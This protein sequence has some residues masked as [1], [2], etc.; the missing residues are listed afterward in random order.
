MTKRVRGVSLVSKPDDYVAF[1]NANE[2]PQFAGV[3]VNVLDAALKE[4]VT[5][6]SRHR[7]KDNAQMMKSL[8]RVVVALAIAPWR[9][10]RAQPGHN[11]VRQT[12]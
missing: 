10:R 3:S 4:T 11:F 7:Q 2:A 9:S 6:L 12:A 5:P 8:V 1:D